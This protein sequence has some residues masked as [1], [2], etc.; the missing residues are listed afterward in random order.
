MKPRSSFAARFAGVS[1]AR[2]ASSVAALVLVTGCATGPN[3]NPADP[4]EPLNRQVARFN[5]TVDD[6]VLRPVATIYQRVLP[7]PVRTGVNNFFGNL[8]DIWS[9][10]NSALQLKLQ[11]S[12][13]TFARVNVNTFFGLGGLL[14]IATEA[15]L[16]RHSEDFGQTLGRWGVPSGPYL[17]LPLLGPSTL[18]DTAALPLDFRGDALSYVNNIP[19]RNSLIAL[20]LVDLRS[21][22]LRASQLLEDAAL[23]R[24]T[25]TR[26][27]FLQRR[28]SEVY[29]GN[30]PD[31]EK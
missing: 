4:L 1:A 26:D 8:S 20:R 31:E 30:L 23:D 25:F 15:G 3:A 2:A 16:D 28:R 14:D 22:L 12:A 10:V 21:N 5:D 27:A 6:A 24:Y 18:R 9:F 11:D 7:S 13:Q 19:V 17:V 29:E